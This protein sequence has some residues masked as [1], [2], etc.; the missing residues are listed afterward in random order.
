VL[1][2]ERSAAADFAVLQQTSCA[3]TKTGKA[4]HARCNLCQIFVYYLF[5][6]FIHL[7]LQLC[8]LENIV[9]MPA[10]RSNTH[11]APKSSKIPPFNWSENDATLTWKLIGE[12]EKKENY[13][14]LFGKKD[15]AEVCNA[16]MYTHS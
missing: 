1:K 7:F 11:S 4:C 6:G 16:Y 12:L 8:Y 15:K 10:I 3:P 14:V 5:T 13:R 2:V 9:V